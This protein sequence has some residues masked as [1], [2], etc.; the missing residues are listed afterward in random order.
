MIICLLPLIVCSYFPFAVPAHSCLV[1]ASTCFLSS[2]KCA[3]QM[4]AQCH[5]LSFQ[6]AE[7]ALPCLPYSVCG[8]RSSSRSCLHC[9]PP[10]LSRLFSAQNL[11]FCNSLFTCYCLSPQISSPT[12][13]KHGIFFFPTT[14]HPVSNKHCV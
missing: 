6:A 14:T 4:A 1:R 12:R 9:V 2:L 10:Y 13:A 11:T 5:L 3:F 8:N 7:N